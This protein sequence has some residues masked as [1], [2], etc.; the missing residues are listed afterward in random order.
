MNVLSRCLV[1]S[2][3][4]PYHICPS[5]IACIAW[6]L[7]CSFSMFPALSHWQPLLLVLLP[8]PWC[9]V[10]ISRQGNLPKALGLLLL[11]S[12]TSSSLYGSRWIRKWNELIPWTSFLARSSALPSCI[13]SFLCQQVLVFLACTK[14]NRKE[15]SKKAEI[16]AESRKIKTN[17][18]GIFAITSQ[19]ANHNKC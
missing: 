10:F 16:A 8:S 15:E 11:V 4:A 5:P 9:D 2:Q 1:P 17:T 18:T 3:P 12:P 14:E 6:L 13:H 7:D 19:K